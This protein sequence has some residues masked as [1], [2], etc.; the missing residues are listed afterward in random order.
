METGECS[1][2]HRPC[3]SGAEAAAVQ[4]LARWR[5]G[6]RTSRSVGDAQ[7]LWRF[8]ARLVLSTVVFTLNFTD[9]SPL[10]FYVGR[11]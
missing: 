10:G 1:Y 3:E 8:G 5:V 6:Q 7:D 4:A 2:I 11:G 9:P